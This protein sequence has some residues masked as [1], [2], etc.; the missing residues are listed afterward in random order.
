METRSSDGSVGAEGL[1]RRELLRLA[2]AGVVLP[3]LPTLAT[4]CQSS[5]EQEVGRPLTGLY[6]AWVLRLYPQLAALG[7]PRPEI[8]A[9][10]REIL[11]RQAR[12]GTAAVDFYVGLTPFDDLV[13][14]RRANV[15]APW[16]EVMPASVAADLPDPVRRESTL[17]GGL[18]SWPLL[19]D[20]T[21]LGSNAELVERADL[22]PGRPPRTWDELADA[23]RQVVRSG[24]APFGCTFDPRPWRSLVPV[25]HSF[26]AD[27]YDEQGRFDYRADAAAG[28]LETLRRLR[29]LANPDIL[30]GAVSPDGSTPDE[31]AFAGGLAAYYVKYQNAPI[32]MAAGWADPG[33]LVLARLPRPLDGAGKTVFWTTGV[34]LVRFGHKKPDVARYTRSITYGDDFWRTAIGGGRAAGGHIPVFDSLWRDWERDRPPWLGAWALG[35]HEQLKHAEPI[36]PSAAG[37]EQFKGRA[38]AELDRY[39]AGEEPSA[40]RA[41]SRAAAG[42]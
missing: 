34:G 17:D 42:A 41:L 32:R 31:Q 40:R 21:I 36:P 26:S 24:A 12:R 1:S 29:E 35:V 18:Y 6:Q 27:V 16:D 39:L 14:L 38:R 4:G 5:A 9:G 10:T 22:D 11:S 37:F 30:D 25:T 15:L 28:A 19:L 13:R 7:S 33:R 3:L 8:G 23:A 2:A 20:V